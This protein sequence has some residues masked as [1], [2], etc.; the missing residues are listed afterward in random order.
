MSEINYGKWAYGQLDDIK[1]RTIRSNQIRL[2]PSNDIALIRERINKADELSHERQGE[3]RAYLDAICIAFIEEELQKTFHDIVVIKQ[4]QLYT[5]NRFIN[6]QHMLL[7]TAREYEFDHTSR[8][9]NI[10]NRHTREH[11]HVMHIIERI[12]EAA[13]AGMFEGM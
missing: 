2:R 4:R 1:D 6:H 12:A 13:R 7:E 10:P 8:K 11:F 5:I 9:S 3:I